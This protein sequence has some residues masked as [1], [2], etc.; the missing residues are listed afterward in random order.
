M[1]CQPPVWGFNTDGFVKCT[2]RPQARWI[3]LENPNG[4]EGLYVKN[5]YV[6]HCIDKQRLVLFYNTLWD[7]PLDYPEADIPDGYVLT[8]DRRCCRMRWRG[9]SPALASPDKHLKKRPGQL[10]VAWSM[11]CKV[12]YPAFLSSRGSLKL[13]T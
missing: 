5:V 9:L 2:I 6:R 11:E 4:N 10:W 3:D 8:T 7:Q 1:P 13:L 12:N